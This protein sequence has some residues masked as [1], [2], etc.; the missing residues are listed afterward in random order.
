MSFPFKIVYETTG[1][2]T[3]VPDQLNYN[4]SWITL[5]NG[6]QNVSPTLCCYELYTLLGRSTVYSSRDNR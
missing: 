2:T 1:T 3:V 6:I 5:Y 4:Y